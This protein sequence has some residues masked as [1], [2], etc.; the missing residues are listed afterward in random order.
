MNYLNESLAKESGLELDDLYTDNNE[1]TEKDFQFQCIDCDY[2]GT[3][4]WE[5]N[6]CNADV[7]GYCPNC[8]GHR[9]LIALS[10]EA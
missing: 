8:R 10:K 2:I 4:E 5:N 3:G 6:E 7:T 9:T 1:L